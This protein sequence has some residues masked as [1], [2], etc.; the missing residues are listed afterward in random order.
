[1]PSILTNI[2][3]LKI[4]NKYKR[5]ISFVVFLPQRNIDV[6]YVLLHSNKY[7]HIKYECIMLRIK[8]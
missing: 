6:R 7:N 3:Q 5:L 1:M 4:Q 8:L 2:V